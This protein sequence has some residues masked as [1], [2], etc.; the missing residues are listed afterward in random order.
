MRNAATEPHH[1][2]VVQ[3]MREGRVARQTVYFVHERYARDML[4]RHGAYLTAL[5]APR[6]AQWL[7][8]AWRSGALYGRGWFRWDE[9]ITSFRD[10]P[11]KSVSSRLVQLIA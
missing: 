9:P 6:D 5:R 7:V 3:E 8:D 10:V 4:P 1:G 11:C 2:I